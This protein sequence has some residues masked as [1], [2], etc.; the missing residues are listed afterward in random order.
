MDA[1]QSLKLV[2]HNMILAPPGQELVPGF[3]SYGPVLAIPKRAITLG[4]KTG[5]PVV[6]GTTTVL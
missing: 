6:P 3:P 2:Q 4:T 5:I 1:G